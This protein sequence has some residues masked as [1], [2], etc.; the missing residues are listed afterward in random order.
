M[1]KLHIKFLLRKDRANT[2]GYFPIYFY[3]NINGEVKYFTMNQ[4]VPIK[5]WNEKKQEVSVTF[6]NWNTINYDIARYRD[7]AANADS[8]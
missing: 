7:K 1:N 4:F 5:A 8:C 6:P 2:N 3:A